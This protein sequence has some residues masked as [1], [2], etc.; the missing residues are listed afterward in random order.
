MRRWIAG[1]LS[2]LLVALIA[3]HAT[4]AGAARIGA[5]RAST[6]DHDA[7]KRKLDARDRRRAR[8]IRALYHG[9]GGWDRWQIR[10]VRVHHGTIRI[11]TRLYAKA[12][13]K[14]AFIGVCTTAMAGRWVS[15]IDVIGSD[16]WRHGSWLRDDNGCRTAGL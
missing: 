7:L 16:G 5:G 4:G 11:R 3:A 1:A 9:I 10:S 2:V 8:S 6:A 13:N 12:S 15:R 14:P